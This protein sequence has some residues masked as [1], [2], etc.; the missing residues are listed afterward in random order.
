MKQRIL[1]VALIAVMVLSLT[2]TGC[3]NSSSSSGG[4]NQRG[5]GK[6]VGGRQWKTGRRGHADA[7]LGKVDQRRP[8]HEGTAGGAWL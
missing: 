2:L 8:E 4:E 7:E 5:N 3:G 1:S 6:K